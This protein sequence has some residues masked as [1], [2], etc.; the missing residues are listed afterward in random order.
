[1]AISVTLESRS[2]P[3]LVKRKSRGRL[4]QRDAMKRLSSDVNS[5]KAV[6]SP[7]RNCEPSLCRV[8]G[9]DQ[10]GERADNGEEKKKRAIW[11]QSPRHFVADLAQASSMATSCRLGAKVPT[12]SPSSPD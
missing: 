8:G 10:H 7:R 1:M 5:S 3:S 9:A 2:F 12:Q 6:V 11:S 4:G